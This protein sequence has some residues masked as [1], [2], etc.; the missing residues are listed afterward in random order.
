[1]TKNTNNITQQREFL[2][3]PYAEHI[4]P[5]PNFASVIM[6]HA[7]EFP[8]K[9]ALGF[10]SRSYT[11]SELLQTC[12]ELELKTY[13]TLTMKDTENDLIL[14]LALLL[15]GIPFN[16]DFKANSTLKLIEI[17][18]QKKDIHYFE[19]PY[20]RLDD[21]ALILN[22]ELSFSQYNILVAAQ[23]IGNAFKLF[24]PGNALCPLSITSIADLSFGILAPLYFAK[25]IYFD[26]VAEPD[27][28]Q[29]AWNGVIRSDLRD[30][31]MVGSEIKDQKNVYNLKK[32]FDNAMGIGK[33]I[34]SEGKEVTFLG[35]E[36]EDEE[37]RGHCLGRK[38][39]V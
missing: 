34:S 6:Q 23:A 12:L 18:R 13:I 24:R 32:S 14:L 27:F 31:V 10:D 36:I 2:N 19:P 21:E 35:F 9:I 8:D 39:L 16:L 5:F 1:M 30:A 3:I 7:R 25:S 15:Q 37:P 38:I 29:Y 28:F 11:Y 17:K 22:N 33:V 26:D 20:V 4:V